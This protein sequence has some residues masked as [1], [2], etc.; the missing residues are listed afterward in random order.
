MQKVVGS[1]PI[2]RFRKA[3]LRRGFSGAGAGRTHTLSRNFVPR[4]SAR[5]SPR[6]VWRPSEASTRAVLNPRL[7]VASETSP[8]PEEIHRS[9][10]RRTPTLAPRRPRPN[11]LAAL[12]TAR[13]RTSAADHL[14]TVTTPSKPNRHHCLPADSSVLRLLLRPFL[15]PSLSCFAAPSLALN[16]LHSWAGPPFSMGVEEG[17][18]FAVYALAAVHA[19]WTAVI[20]RGVGAAA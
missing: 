16:L 20:S 18:T 7:E 17:S 9:S 4:L 6:S 3:L 8:D 2:S 12:G 10:E 1:N 5:W 15:P 11:R 13:L 19:C 14:R